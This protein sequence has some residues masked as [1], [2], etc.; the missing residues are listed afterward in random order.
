MGARTKARKRA[1]DILFEA[2]QRGLNAAELVRER[3]ANPVTSDPLNPYTGEI[4]EGV[5]AHWLEIDDLL[6]TYSMGWTLER[7]PDV[8]RSLLR[9]GV[10][11]IVWNDDVP[12]EVAMSEA[13]AL[14]TEL[15]TDE[16]PRFINGL[17]GRISDIKPTLV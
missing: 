10:W 5:V 6:S 7:M 1:L 3:L 15:S 4:V 8:D 11:E 2:E 16:S 9:I 17:L 14:A 12:D 13:V